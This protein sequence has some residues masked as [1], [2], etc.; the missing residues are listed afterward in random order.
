MKNLAEDAI[1]AV[2]MKLDPLKHPYT[3]ELLGLD[4]MIDSNFK[5]WL[6]EINT[7]PCLETSGMVL[8]RIIPNLVE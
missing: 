1:R 8:N 4:F 3:F 5:P 2:Y 6:I 7:N